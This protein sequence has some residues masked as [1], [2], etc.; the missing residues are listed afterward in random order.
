MLR[1]HISALLLFTVLSIS[2]QDTKNIK[3]EL[4]QVDRL[5][6]EKNYDEALIHVE[7][8]LSYDE[9]NLE[10]LERK[11]NIF[12]LSGDEKEAFKELDSKISEF[13]Q[14]PEYYYLRSILF[15][16]KDKPQK[17]IEDLDNAEYYYMPENYMYKVDLYRG[18]AYQYLGDISAA[19]TNFKAAVKLN[20]RD[21]SIW[22]SWGMMKYEE[23]QYEEAI[24]Y[25]NK[26][27]FI[28]D[29]DPIAY[30]N[31]GMAYLKTDD[32]K[33][34]CYNFNRSCNLNHKDACKIYIMECTE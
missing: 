27:I 15:I 29:T 32:L 20:P 22:H 26:S 12:L 3:A 7:K 2:A 23:R 5:I 1:L 16:Y 33:N 8:A 19:E 10:A 31:L 25:F 9:L 11:V 21:A 18:V 4:K 28:R 17:A 30:Y 24:E 34:A 14:Q 13:P 6:G